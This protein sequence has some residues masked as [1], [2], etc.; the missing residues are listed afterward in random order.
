MHKFIGV[1]LDKLPWDL[2]HL[3][4]PFACFLG[5]FFLSLS[6]SPLLHQLTKKREQARMAKVSFFLFLLVALS[7]SQIQG[8]VWPD[9]ENLIGLWPLSNQYKL[10]NANNDNEIFNS[11][12]NFLEHRLPHLFRSFFLLFLRLSLS[13][14]VRW[15]LVHMA[16]MVLP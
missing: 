3:P 6:F 2:E 9:P 16:L 8:Q 10:N 1:F 4:R 7:I 12:C 14:L 13:I 5:I 15:C 11:V